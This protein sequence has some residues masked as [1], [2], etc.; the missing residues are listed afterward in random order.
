MVLVP[1]KTLFIDQG[2]QTIVFLHSYT[3]SPNDFRPTIRQVAKA[4]FS[5]YAP[6]FRGHGT[7]NPTDILTKGNVSAWWQDTQAAIEFIQ[8]QNK[9][10]WAIFGLSLGSIFAMKAL[11]LYP[12]IVG[13]GVLGSPLFSH[14]FTNVRA[15]FFDYV[16]IIDQHQK[17]GMAQ[18]ASH[19]RL[20]EERLNPALDSIAQAANE[21]SQNLH[22][23][24]QPIFIGHGAQDEMVDY[25]AAEQLRKHLTTTVDFHLYPQAGHV[26]TVNAARPQL[27]KDLLQFITTKI[28]V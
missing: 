20:V 9:Q 16:R 27:E 23:V 19:K 14:E 24:K 18:H 3:G 8:Q 6:L 22:L 13:G 28:G 25:Q 4:N 17:V 21:V 2:P 1:P 11:E 5:V 26:I 7:N 15:G 12:Q 10:V